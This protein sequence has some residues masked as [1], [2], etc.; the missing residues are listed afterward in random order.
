MSTPWPQHCTALHRRWGGGGSLSC[1]VRNCVKGVGL[2][3]VDG[4]R[5]KSTVVTRNKLIH[6]RRVLEPPPHRVRCTRRC[7]PHTVRGASGRDQGYHSTHGLCERPHSSPARAR[8]IY[9]HRA[10]AC[11]CSRSSFPR[12]LPHNLFLTIS[13]SRSLPRPLVHH[14]FVA[15]SLATPTPRLHCTA[16]KDDGLALG[17]GAGA[18]GPAPAQ[19]RQ[20]EED[21]RLG[22]Q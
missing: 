10:R 20:E 17:H 14:L 9:R 18:V 11:F 22:R 4:S 6:A 12:P 21:G 13:S 8:G 16:G 1:V 2:P 5:H 3:G 7:P 19:G 15:L